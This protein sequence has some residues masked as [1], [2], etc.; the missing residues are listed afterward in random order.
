MSFTFSGINFES[1]RSLDLEYANF[2]G[3]FATSS[4]KMNNHEVYTA[5]YTFYDTNLSKLEKLY[6]SGT[7]FA[8][9]GMGK[10]FM[11]TASNTFRNSNLSNVKYLN[12]SQAYFADENMISPISPC[13]VLTADSTFM[14]ANFN[15]VTE[16]STSGT[17]FSF[18]N[19]VDVTKTTNTYVAS[20]YNTF[21]HSS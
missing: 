12:L 19:M 14:G 6:L 4:T 21:D 7:R 18:V 17:Y 16:F 10:Y 20:C 2:A 13:N 8:A 1:L 11:N 9:T 15:S 3:S 5:L